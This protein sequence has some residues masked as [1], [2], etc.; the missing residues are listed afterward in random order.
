M[1]I[2]ATHFATD[3]S[4][5]GSIGYGLAVAVI[6]LLVLIVGHI[7]RQLNTVFKTVFRADRRR[8]RAPSD[9]ILARSCAVID[10]L[11]VSGYNE[12]QAIHAVTTRTLKVDISLSLDKGIA[13]GR[14]SLKQCRDNLLA[15]VASEAARAEYYLFARQIKGLLASEVLEQGLW[16]RRGAPLPNCRFRE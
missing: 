10:L 16:D 6:C 12:A 13:A 14:R 3:E 7:D 4:G 1:E 2:F 9:T 8:G 5:A 15:G 11:V